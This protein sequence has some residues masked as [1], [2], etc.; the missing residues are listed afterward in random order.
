[1]TADDIKVTG[2]YVLGFMSPVAYHRNTKLENVLVQFDWNLLAK[3]LF[4][5]HFFVHCKLP[6]VA[7]GVNLVKFFSHWTEEDFKN[8]KIYRR[9]EGSE[10]NVIKKFN[11]SGKFNI[12]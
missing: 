1:M 2:P 12:I 5:L 10:R 7:S 6:V 8:F 4:P 9:N 3:F 11:V